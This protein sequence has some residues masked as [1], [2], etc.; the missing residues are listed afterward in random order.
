MGFFAAGVEEELAA[1]VVMGAFVIVLGF[2]GLHQRMER[3]YGLL[4]QL[5]AAQQQPL[6][7]RR[8]IGQAKAGQQFAPIKFHRFYQMATAG[9]AG[10]G[11]GV[12]MLGAGPQKRLKVGDIRRDR[13]RQ[14]PD[15]LTCTFDQGRPQARLR[16]LQRHAQAMQ[17]HAQVIQRQCLVDFRP[18][19]CGQPFAA[20]GEIA[21]QGQVTQQSPNFISWKGSNRRRLASDFKSAQGAQC[22]ERHP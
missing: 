4:V 11:M 22:Q 20:L 7:K 9:R 15:R 19:K 3:S 17:R 13:G 6:F 10:V 2:V 1:G 5:F 16:F 12:W 18:E 21:L 14:E 8:C